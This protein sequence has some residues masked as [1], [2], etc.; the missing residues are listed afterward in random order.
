M[1]AVLIN[2]VFNMD[3]IYK[4]VSQVNVNQLPYV[5][6]NYI[7]PLK[8]NK[9]AEGQEAEMK[10]EEPNADNIADSLFVMKRTTTKASSVSKLSISQSKKNDKGDDKKKKRKGN[11]KQDL[12]PTRN[13]I[14]AGDFNHER[15][16]FDAGNKDTRKVNN[17]REY[18]HQRYKFDGARRKRSNSKKPKM[19]MI[20]QALATNVLIGAAIFHVIHLGL[21]VL[22]FTAAYKVR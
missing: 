20:G 10:G 11:M 21:C 9:V 17:T 19:L 1:V 3:Q 7:F 13:I 18:Y 4:E 6:K 22:L 12:F 8:N 2:T 15:H 5:I 14:N 16:I